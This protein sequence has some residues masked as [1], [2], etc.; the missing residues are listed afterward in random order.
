M[1][2]LSWFLFTLLAV[3]HGL[4]T[5]HQYPRSDDTSSSNA[6]AEIDPNAFITD[7]SP[8]LSKS[9]RTTTMQDG[10]RTV[11]LIDGSKKLDL[12][13]SHCSF[14]WG[15]IIGRWDFL[16]GTTRTNATYMDMYRDACKNASLVPSN[17]DQLSNPKWQATMRAALAMNANNSKTE[18]DGYLNAVVPT[19]KDVKSCFANNPLTADQER[20]EL[21]R[22]LQD[23]GGLN[24]EGL[25]EVGLA[26]SLAILPTTVIKLSTD[27]GQLF[28]PSMSEEDRQYVHN[29]LSPLLTVTSAV[30]LIFMA[31]V[32]ARGAIGDVVQGVDI[33]VAAG[34]LAFARREL[35]ALATLNGLVAAVT[36]EDFTQLE[37][38]FNQMPPGLQGS[39]EAD[40]LK[41]IDCGVDGAISFSAPDLA[42]ANVTALNISPLMFVK[43]STKKEQDDGTCPALN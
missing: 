29:T 26:I 3:A 28:Q 2:G 7:P 33:L 25:R 15:Q 42:T 38:E 24:W 39:L 11:T 32:L 23:D 12:S 35:V 16:D 18:A 19:L 20:F 6:S 13:I 37:K 36:T 9:R 4:V 40:T 5:K 30:G 8:A 22:L 31:S 43:D 10:L 17:A 14:R 34:G 21:R 27:I 41:L 1:L